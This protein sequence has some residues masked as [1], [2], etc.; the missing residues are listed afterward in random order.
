MSIHSALGTSRELIRYVIG[1]TQTEMKQ[2]KYVVGSAS[3]ETSRRVA[4]IGSM[5]SGFVAVLT[6]TLQDLSDVARLIFSNR[7]YSVGNEIGTAV[8]MC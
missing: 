5:C 4:H 8:A 6:R 2:H 7:F 3:L 1:P